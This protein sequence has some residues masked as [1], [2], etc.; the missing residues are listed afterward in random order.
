MKPAATA[1]GGENGGEKQDA[2]HAVVISLV[3]ST[4]HVFT[5]HAPWQ[6]LYLY[7]A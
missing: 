7:P 3:V 2:V 5:T 1:V 6:Y 4:T